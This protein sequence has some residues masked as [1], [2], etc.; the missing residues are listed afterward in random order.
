MKSELL[1]DPRLEILDIIDKESSKY[2]HTEQYVRFDDQENIIG[3]CINGLVMLH[4]GWQPDKTE[5]LCPGT[6]L[7][8]NWQNMAIMMK[9]R[10]GDDVI[11]DINVVN[12]GAP[13]WAECKEQLKEYWNLP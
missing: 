5:M 7:P 6:G 2:Q 9:K 4:F 11:G 1:L 3:C 10:Y 12:S 13:S 8:L